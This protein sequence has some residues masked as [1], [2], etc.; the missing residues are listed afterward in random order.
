MASLPKDGQRAWDE[1]TQ[2]DGGCVCVPT[3]TVLSCMMNKCFWWQLLHA[4][5]LYPSW[6]DRRGMLRS[7]WFHRDCLSFASK[8]AI[9]TN[10]DRTKYKCTSW[11]LHSKIWPQAWGYKLCQLARQ[12]CRVIFTWACPMDWVEWHMCG[13]Y[14]GPQNLSQNRCCTGT[15]S[16]HFLT[17]NASHF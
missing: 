11:L 6:H 4:K 8:E 17:E 12:A 2:G 7:I 1:T 15:L 16:M 5:V 13:P 10:V 3:T 14:F 9:K